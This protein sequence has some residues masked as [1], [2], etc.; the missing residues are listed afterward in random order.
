[1]AIRQPTSKC[2][3][4]RAQDLPVGAQ[5]RNTWSRHVDVSIESPKSSSGLLSTESEAIESKMQCRSFLKDNGIVRLVIGGRRPGAEKKDR[6]KTQ[7]L[8]PQSF[9]TT[10]HHTLFTMASVQVVNVSLPSLPSGWSADKDFKSVGSLSAAIQRN[11]EPVGPHFLA[12]ARRVCISNETL[13][14][15]CE[16]R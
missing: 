1:M 14:Y 6:Q 10:P 3:P 5:S 7:L 12:H 9:E 2:D 15:R 4:G 13:I 8:I 16:Q 11:I